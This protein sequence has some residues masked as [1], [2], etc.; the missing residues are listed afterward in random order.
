MKEFKT[1]FL[2]LDPNNYYHRRNEMTTTDDLDFKHHN[3]KEMRQVRPEHGLSNLALSQSSKAW[4]DKQP[5]GASLVTKELKR[6][7]KLTF[8]HW[9]L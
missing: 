7:S 1:I 5:D 8:S 6:G 2:F 9:S 3:Y 4:A